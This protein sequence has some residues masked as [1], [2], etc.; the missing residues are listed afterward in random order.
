[1]SRTLY[2]CHSLHCEFKRSNLSILLGSFSFVAMPHVCISTYVFH[3][4]CIQ[5]IFKKI[6]KTN[7]RLINKIMH[8]ITQ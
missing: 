6:D 4:H 2:I 7:A 5:N 8:C 1:M 3:V